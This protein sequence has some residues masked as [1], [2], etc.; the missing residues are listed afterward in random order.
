MS[1]QTLGSKIRS[2]PLK[3]VPVQRETGDV[4]NHT[5]RIQRRTVDLDHIRLNPRNPRQ[6]MDE[7]QLKELADSIEV[8]GCL[9]PPLVRTLPGTDGY[10]EVVAGSRRV[11]AHALLKR[12]TVDVLIT[13]MPDE[14]A[15]LASAVENLQRVD[16]TPR[17][18]LDLVSYL[19]N[20]HSARAIAH[21][22]GKSEAWVSRRKHIL[23]SPLLTAAITAGSLSL[24]RAYDLA[25]QSA[26][27]EPRISAYLDSLAAAQTDASASPSDDAAAQPAPDSATTLPPPNASPA[28]QPPTDGTAQLQPETAKAHRNRRRAYARL[29]DAD[30]MISQLR[31]LEAAEP[32]EAF[33]W[34]QALRSL[35]SHATTQL[36]A[37]RLLSEV[38]TDLFDLPDITTHEEHDTP[39]QADSRQS[40]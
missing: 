8:H 29:V 4:L 39:N 40:A 15:F 5:D 1:T 28:V 18:Q 7:A 20:H 34:A 17:E 10:Y 12:E 21:Q 9:Q 30:R 33:A 14:E 27:D 32:D 36:K 31:L 26:D 22:L 2:Q 38:D 19:L 13:H 6:A 23:A 24:D 25:I 3:P 11:A 16:L 35:I 37:L